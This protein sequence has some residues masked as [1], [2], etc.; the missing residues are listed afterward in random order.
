MSIL[1]NHISFSGDQNCT[2]ADIARFKQDVKEEVGEGFVGTAREF[3][4]IANPDAYKPTSY[5][6]E[7]YKSDFDIEIV[8]GRRAKKS[9]YYDKV[10]QEINDSH[11]KFAFKSFRDK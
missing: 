6:G 2:L 11:D 8:A 1:K 9:E 5:S 10:K 7:K 3:D 4:K